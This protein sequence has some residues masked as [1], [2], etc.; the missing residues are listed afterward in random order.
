MMNPGNRV[1]PG[2][3]NGRT[4]RSRA[5]IATAGILLVVSATSVTAHA[6]GPRCF[7]KSATIVGTNGNDVLRG[8][9]RADVIVARGGSDTVRA[10]EGNDRV[11]AGAGHDLVRGAAGRDKIKGGDGLDLLWGSSGK[12]RIIGGFFRSMDQGELDWLDGGG[13]D[14][15]LLG[16]SAL[17]A[18]RGRGG[19]DVIRGRGNNDDFYTEVVTGG[20]GADRIKGGPAARR[21]ELEENFGEIFIRGPGNDHIDGGEAGEPLDRID[22]V[23]YWASP[24]KITVSLIDGTATGQGNDTFVD[25]GGVIGSF[26]DDDIT[27]DGE[28]NLIHGLEGN[29]SVDAGDGNDRVDGEGLLLGNLSLRPPWLV[30]V[31]C[32]TVCDDALEGGGGND[33]AI[34]GVGVDLVQGGDGDDV[35]YGG[36]FAFEQVHDGNDELH[37]D[38]GDDNLNAQLDDDVLD[39]GLGS[40]TNDGGPGIDAC[41]N[42]DTAG[43]AENCESP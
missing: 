19:N 33:T 43:G 42:P 8:T 7:G 18:I 10:K 35:L 30:R 29:D 9:N 17:D 28:G 20:G 34:G 15:T 14:D 3:L 27:G 37:G 5:G 41:T 21:L 22:A 2:E 26:S 25:I 38:A 6:A 31:G 36:A 12:D 16:S 39:G 32:Q 40:N 1:I 4:M 24:R 11:C 13:G 23:A